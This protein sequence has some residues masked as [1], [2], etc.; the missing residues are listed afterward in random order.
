MAVPESALLL[1][2]HRLEFNAMEAEVE[3]A[4]AEVVAYGGGGGA[5]EVTGEAAAEAPGEPSA[6]AIKSIEG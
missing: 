4:E 5:V 1:L 6:M 2:L 3:V